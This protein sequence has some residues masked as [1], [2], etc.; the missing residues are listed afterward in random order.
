MNRRMIELLS[1]FF[2]LGV[3]S[4]GDSCF[5]AKKK[6][7]K[8]EPFEMHK[9]RLRS[10]MYVPLTD[11]EKKIHH[12]LVT[13][14]ED[15]TVAVWQLSSGACIQTFEGFRHDLHS[16]TSLIVN[17][18]KVMIV[19]GLTDGSM[20]LILL[21]EKYPRQVN[22]GKNARVNVFEKIDN[23][24]LFAGLA[25]GSLCRLTFK[26]N[27]VT[28]DFPI[29]KL[30]SVVFLRYI[31]DDK[32]IIVCGDGIVM[33]FDIKQNTIVS[34]TSSFFKKPII[35]IE[36]LPSQ[37]AL[38]CLKSGLW[39][40]DLV[41]EKEG[42]KFLANVNKEITAFLKWDYTT[43][44]VGCSDGTCYRYSAEENKFYF[45]EK[46]HKNSIISL[47]KNNDVLIVASGVGAIKQL[48]LVKKTE[49]VAFQCADGYSPVVD[50]D[51]E[52]LF[53]LEI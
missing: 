36:S 48:N 37:K 2:L 6:E 50:G 39:M 18:E 30:G 13:I 25:D 41:Q 3:T 43:F 19:V 34:K 31:G 10:M 33:V 16:L 44:I 23:N 26:G 29:K 40:W 45:L 7:S 47:A 15:K 53:D 1:L 52:E 22:T 8:K 49:G 32:I 17:G 24:T 42:V 11:I 21:D 14:A 27:D 35:G 9:G 46:V 51:D 5:C 38:V 12:R 4:W 28:V 20:R